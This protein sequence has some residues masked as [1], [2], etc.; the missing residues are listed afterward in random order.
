MGAV[1]I[2]FRAFFFKLMVYEVVYLL[3]DACCH[4]IFINFPAKTEEEKLE[5]KTEV[6]TKLIR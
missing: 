3:F 5:R 2:I 1:T 4:F 6:G